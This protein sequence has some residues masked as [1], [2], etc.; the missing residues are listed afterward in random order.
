MDE[1]PLFTH[2]YDRDVAAGHLYRDDQV[3]HR[4]VREDLLVCAQDQAWD[5][6][7]LGRLP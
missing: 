7:G 3:A 1:M 5:V 6:G 4:A 2:A